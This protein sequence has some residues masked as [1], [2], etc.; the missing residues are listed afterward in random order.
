MKA[1]IDVGVQDTTWF[2][3]LRAIHRYK[4]GLKKGEGGSFP[5]RRAGEFCIICSREGVRKGNKQIKGDLVLGKSDFT[6]YVPTRVYRAHLKK[7]G[8]LF[9]K[10]QFY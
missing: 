7:I 1:S 4:P 5:A 2:L 6:E 9:Y 10:S 3:L 8:F